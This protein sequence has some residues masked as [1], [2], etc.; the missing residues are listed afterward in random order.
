MASNTIS[1]DTTVPYKSS[2][3]IPAVDLSL[4]AGSQ[5]VNTLASSLAGGQPLS[6]KW[7]G[8]KGD[9]V[10]DDAAAIRAAMAAAGYGG[11]IDFPPSSGAYIINSVINVAPTNGTQSGLQFTGSRKGTVISPGASM[12]QLFNITGN[13]VSF[14]GI[15]FTNVSNHAAN[16]V[17]LTQASEPSDYSVLFDNCCFIGFNAAT[18]NAGIVANKISQ[19]SITRCEFINNDVHLLMTDVQNTTIDGNYMLGGRIGMHWL[20]GSGESQALEPQGVQIT[21]NCILLNV[22]N[23]AG[24]Q[25]D[26]AIEFYIGSNVVDCYATGSTAVLMNT[27]G[28]DAV[29]AIKLIGNWL[30]G[31]AGAYS[32]FCAGNTSGIDLIS[33]TILPN[34]SNTYLAGISLSSTNGYT[35]IANNFL[36]MPGLPPEISTS[37]TVNG[38]VFGN[39]SSNSGGN[40]TTNIVTNIATTGVAGVSAGKFTLSSTATITSGAGAPGTVV[41]PAGSL[42]LNTSGGAGA[43]LYV[44]Q[45]GGSWTAVA[46]V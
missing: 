29:A 19:M 27:S 46:S 38:N 16:G 17:A 28:S 24:I 14:T 39:K 22:A 12:T 4:P 30:A 6:V 41:Q 13:E 10:T 1:G 34:N 20:L 35:I 37:G 15:S 45:G 11:R 43:H 9:G 21:N 33:N 44:S 32:V 7:F 2:L 8:A 25:I 23:G 5:N 40:S 42:Y 36:A 31:G 18:G 3:L 26:C